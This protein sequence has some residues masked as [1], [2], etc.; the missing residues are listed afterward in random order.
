MDWVLK[1]FFACAALQA[2]FYFLFSR[3]NFVRRV[4]GLPE[5]PL[6]VSIVICA[7]NE[8]ENLL[9]NLKVVLIQQHPQFEV[10]VVND[11]STDNTIDVLV[12]FYK[13]NKNLKIVNVPIEEKKQYAGKKTALLKG[14]E[15][16]TYD[17][18]V[19][20]DA[21]CCPSS[22]LWLAKMMACY[23]DKTD[24]VL[25]FSPFTKKN[26]WVSKLI[27]YE[28]FIT[29]LQ[30]FGFAI[31][32]I[33]YMGVGRNLSFNKQVLNH[34]KGYDKAK[35]VLTGDDD[36]LVNAKAGFRNTE[37]CIDKD[38]F[39]YT[40]PKATLSDWLNQKHR[41]L[42][43]GFHYK[44]IHQ[45]LLFL[46]AA[47]GFLLY[48]SLAVLLVKGVFLKWALIAFGFCVALKLVLTF[49]IYKKLGAD[50]LIFLSPFLDVAYSAYLLLIFF[51]ILL[52]PKNSWK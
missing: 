12:D 28:N 13:R 4:R 31:N 45:F 37:L 36:L 17:Y 40:E 48:T 50:D 43:S 6:P 26:T 32:G 8:A 21:D 20:T 34:F 41:H 5:L 49:R 38:A 16:A 1:I 15:A 9:R 7:K 2:L 52:K 46:F 22:T 47:S 35:N 25:G 23:G 3:L 11:Q 24:F 27:R 10:I 29:A 30:Y 44:F 51:L 18:I 19:V 39:T 42:Q 14:I 33:P